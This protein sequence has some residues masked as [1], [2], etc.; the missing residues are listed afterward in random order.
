MKKAILIGFALAVASSS[1]FAWSQISKTRINDNSDSYKIKCNSGTQT[2]VTSSV[3]F[4]QMKQYFSVTI[5]ANGQ[6]G[7]FPNLDN[8]AKMGCGE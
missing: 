2:T 1:A 4:A 6:T 8:A 7:A 3:N 5:K